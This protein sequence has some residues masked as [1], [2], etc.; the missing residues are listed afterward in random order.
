MRPMMSRLA[1]LPAQELA[2]RERLERGAEGGDAAPDMDR[3][4]IERIGNLKEMGERV[5][6]RH[7]DPAGA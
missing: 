1:P 6:Q 4:V 2:L 5:E 7:D 3:L